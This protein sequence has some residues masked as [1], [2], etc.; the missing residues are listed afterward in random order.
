M[1]TKLATAPLL[2][3]PDFSKKFTIYCDASDYSV[4]G[5]LT[6]KSDDGTEGDQPIAYASR[7]LRGAELN[8]TTT[9]KECLA[10]VFSVSV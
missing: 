4:G 1:K 5:V 3:S 2:I 9:E 10:V 6:Q 7:K 8:Y